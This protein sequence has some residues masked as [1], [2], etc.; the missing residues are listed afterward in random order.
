MTP[1]YEDKRAGITIFLGDCFDVMAEGIGPAVDAVI[2][3]PPYSIATQVA[4]G[5][6]NTVNLG[7]LS[8]QERL[9][10]TLFDLTMSKSKTDGRHFVFADGTSYPV[11]FRAMYGRLSTALIVWDKGRIG[12]GRE[13]RKSHELVMHAWSSETPIFSDG[14]GRPDVIRCAPVVDPV[15]P[16][17]KPVGLLTELLRVCGPAVLDPFMGSGSTLV[18]AKATGR[19]AVG[20]DI[21]ERYCEIAARR[22]AQENLFFGSGANRAE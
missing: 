14:V 15:H 18:A 1:Y 13:F 6:E 2:M 19:R 21:E 10:R 8:L 4:A 9:F 22:L 17:E 7:D 20:I 5:R 11:I 3:D 16:A 12:M